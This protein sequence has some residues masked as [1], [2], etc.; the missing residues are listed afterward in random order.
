MVRLN[1]LI[2]NELRITYN[3]FIT[4]RADF[5]NLSK[6]SN[7]SILFQV[8]KILEGNT[9]SLVK[10]LAYVGVSNFFGRGTSI[11][12]LHAI[13]CRSGGGTSPPTR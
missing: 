6:N 12:Y 2:K 9:K 4:T 3:L 5:L 8:K 10:S 7:E 13:R 11:L 1:Y